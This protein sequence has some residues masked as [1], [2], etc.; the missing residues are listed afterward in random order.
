MT[1]SKLNERNLLQRLTRVDGIRGSVKH[2]DYDIKDAR[3]NS[4][5]MSQAIDLYMHA[6]VSTV[7]PTLPREPEQIKQKKRQEEHIVRSETV[8]EVCHVANQ[9]KKDKDECL[10]EKNEKQRKPSYM[11]DGSIKEQKTKTHEHIYDRLD[12]DR[13][14]GYL[15]YSYNKKG[16]HSTLGKNT[17]TGGYADSMS[18]GDFYRKA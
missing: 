4:M 16:A 8:V 11:N 14:A 7:V 1:G 3:Q 9:R 13:A 17:V 18:N 10:R 6:A 15:F 2:H 12:A 5:S